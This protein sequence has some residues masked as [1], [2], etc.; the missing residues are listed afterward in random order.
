[1]NNQFD[2]KQFVQLVEDT[3]VSKLQSIN[4]SST[5]E[6]KLT[7]DCPE[8]YFDI[9]G[10]ADYLPCTSSFI[11]KLRDNEAIPYIKVGERLMFKRSSI[12]AW[13]SGLEHNSPIKNQLNKFRR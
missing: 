2:L 7:V 9:N 3:V 13:L 6:I 1:M 10:L 4:P 5:I 8:T 12:D 11:K